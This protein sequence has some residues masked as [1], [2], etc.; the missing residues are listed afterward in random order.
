MKVFRIVADSSCLIAL[1]QIELFGLLQEVFSKIYIPSAVYDEVVVKGRGEP[2]SGETEA[3]LKD[4]WI[5]MK[6]VNDRTA[7]D[8]LK[9]ILGK[10]ESEVIILC[11]ELRADYALIDERTARH[12]AELMSVDTIGVLG[13]MDL[14]I[15]MGFTIDKRSLVKQLKAVG[16]RISDK[17]YKRMFGDLK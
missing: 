11:K 5:L 14:A 1:A 4:G 6:D 12:R 9:A 15:E 2:G 17:L 16:F 13:I 3:A 8:A 7:I 10:G